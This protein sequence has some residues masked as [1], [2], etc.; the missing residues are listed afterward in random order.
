M[1]YII[2][3][4]LII[5]SLGVMLIIVVRHMPHLAA[6]DLA[7]LP[8]EKALKVKEK[9]I[10]MRLRRKL[11]SNINTFNNKYLIPSLIKIKAFSIKIYNKILDLEKHYKKEIKTKKVDG[12]PM[13]E[14]QNAIKSKIA[15]AE[16]FL[17]KEDYKQAEEIL[18]EVIAIEPKNIQAYLGLGRI[19]RA[20]KNFEHATE[21]YKHILKIEP[22]NNDGLLGLA[23]VAIKQNN[24]ELAIEIFEKL[25]RLNPDN[26]SYYYEQAVTMENLGEYEKA[27]E[28]CQKAVD[29]K[30]NDPKYLDSMLSLSIKSKKK[31]L[32]LK[33]FDRLKDI[34]PENQKLDEIKSRIEEI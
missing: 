16:D 25:T 15:E 18:I 14:K 27:L 17:I 22:N 7:N 32:A 28:S 12:L 2:L 19:Y 34:N 3:L 6:I 33:M 21:I 1:I 24:R 10:E 23:R 30:P 5:L 9:I 26:A 11:S 29:L 20:Q 31:Y 4:A 8:K 13:V